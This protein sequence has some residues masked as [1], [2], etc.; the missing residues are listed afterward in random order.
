VKIGPTAVARTSLV[1]SS[2]TV[3]KNS[4]TKRQYSFYGE[5]LNLKTW[6]IIKEETGKVLSVEEF[7]TW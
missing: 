7:P 6:S 4:K 2:H 3:C 5:S 1:N